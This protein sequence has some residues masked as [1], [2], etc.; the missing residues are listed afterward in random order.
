MIFFV[1]KSETNA[2]VFETLGA[3][4]NSK[5]KTGTQHQVGH[6]LPF[7][8]YYTNFV[9]FTRLVCQTNVLLHVE[10]P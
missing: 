8:D 2:K 6:S 3:K 10:K 7:R 1:P 9:F 5:S 4:Q